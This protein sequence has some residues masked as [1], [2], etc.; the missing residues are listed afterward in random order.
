MTD[1]PTL[2]SQRPPA[3]YVALQRRSL[4]EFVKNRKEAP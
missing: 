1:N 3:D 4:G 2:S